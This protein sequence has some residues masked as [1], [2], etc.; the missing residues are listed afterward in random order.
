MNLRLLETFVAV[1]DERSFTHAAERL[2]VSQPTVSTNV[3]S[4]EQELGGRL[5][6]R[7]GRE[8]RPTRV[9]EL[10][11]RHALRV[12][13]QVQAMEGDLDR[14]LHGLHGRLEVGAS[15]IP[16][17]YWLPRLV[18]AFHRLHP[19]IALTVRIH[20]TAA[21]LARVRD[22]RLEAGIV[23]ARLSDGDL[24]FDRLIDDRLIPVAPADRAEHETAAGRT[25]ELDDLLAMPFVSREP[26]SG[27]RSLFE[28]RLARAGKS[29]DD[30]RVVAELGSTTAVKE[31]VK[32]GLGFTVLSERAVRADLAAG[33]LEELVVPGLGRLERSFYSA[34]HR[35][36][37]HSPLVRALLRFLAEEA[38]AER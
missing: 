18:E 4:L 35:Q 2:G 21:V 3:R 28:R 19:E 36:R 14:Y 11:H 31:A 24:R 15:T 37:A 1:Y 26:G 9:G 16:G 32:A 13:E 33:L 6:D 12:L 29:P 27:T 17:E 25:V 10:L 22:G 20:D 5:F 30:L 34:V 7:V 38:A 23:G 8:V